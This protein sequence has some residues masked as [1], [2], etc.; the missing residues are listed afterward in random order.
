MYNQKLTQVIL[1]PVQNTVEI[2]KQITLLILAQVG[3]RLETLMK[4]IYAYTHVPNIPVL[5]I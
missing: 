5:T 4:I 3:R 2:C 1:P